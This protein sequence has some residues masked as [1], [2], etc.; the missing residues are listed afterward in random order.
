MGLDNEEWI[1]QLKPHLHALK[2]SAQHSQFS[3]FKCIGPKCS[4]ARVLKILGLQMGVKSKLYHFNSSI[5]RINYVIF[6]TKSKCYGSMPFPD[7]GLS[8]RNLTF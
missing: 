5:F 4:L 7:T 1:K 6:T 8:E 2:K 3:T